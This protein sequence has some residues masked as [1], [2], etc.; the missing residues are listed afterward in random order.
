MM[1]TCE[2]RNRERRLQSVSCLQF[3]CLKYGR[4]ITRKNKIRPATEFDENVPLYDN[5][6]NLMTLSSGSVSK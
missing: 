6:V 1:S 4:V 5:A 2:G 3:I